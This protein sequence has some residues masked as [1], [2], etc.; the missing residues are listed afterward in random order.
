[1]HQAIQ[2]RPQGCENSKCI[3]TV[4]LTE[5]ESKRVSRNKCWEIRYLQSWTLPQRRNLPQFT[6]GSFSKA[7]ISSSYLIIYTVKLLN[8]EQKTG[9]EELFTDY[10]PF[11]T[12]NL[13]LNKELWQSRKCQN[14]ALVNTRL[15]KLAKKRRIYIFCNKFCDFTVKWARKIRDPHIIWKPLE[16]KLMI[17]FKKDAIAS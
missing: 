5:A 7:L 4:S 8:K 14:L 11:Y 15:W 12:I 9:F 3:G 17:D 13:L 2:I 16:T 1:M 6:V 10:Q